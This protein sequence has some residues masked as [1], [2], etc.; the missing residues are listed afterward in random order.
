MK[1]SFFALMF[2]GILMGVRV[3]SGQPADCQKQCQEQL[4]N[5]K[6]HCM[7]MGAD[8]TGCDERCVKENTRCLEKCETVKPDSNAADDDDAELDNDADYNDD[9]LDNDSEFED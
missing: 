9:S 5:C 2:A 8:N 7:V 3:L 4:K 1:K 6:A